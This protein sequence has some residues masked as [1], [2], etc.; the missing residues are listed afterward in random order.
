MRSTGISATSH[1]PN[2]GSA[3]TRQTTPAF[4]SISRARSTAVVRKPTGNWRPTVFALRPRM[5]S[6]R[7]L[8]SSIVAPPGTRRKKKLFVVRIAK[9][10][11]SGSPPPSHLCFLLLPFD[12]EPPGRRQLDAALPQGLFRVVDMILGRR[13]REDL[14][15]RFHPRRRTHWCPERGA[16]AFRDAVG[17][18]P[19]GNLVLAEHVVRI[20]AELEV[21]RVP[22]LLR[23][24]AVRRDPRGFEG[25]VTN[26]AC[27]RGD[28]MN[29]HR[30]LRP[31]VP[32]VKLADPDSWH[33]AHVLLAGVRLATDFAVHAAGLARHL[34]RRSK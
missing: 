28:Q 20:Q 27:F 1:A 21:V 13:D 24:V 2:D 31:R 23:D 19:R 7:R 18:G 33:A 8:I 25:D 5:T 32:D 4:V 10:E 22:R 9:S 16:H 30:E 17:P 15:A 26:L 29:L 34:G 11:E 6:S 14:H 12:F 3:E